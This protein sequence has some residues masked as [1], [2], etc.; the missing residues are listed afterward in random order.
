MQFI[1]ASGHDL[2]RNLVFFADGTWND[3][4]NPSRITNVNLLWKMCRDA[5]VPESAQ[6][7]KYQTGVGTEGGFISRLTGGAFAKGLDDNIIDA[8]I[9][10]ASNYKPSDRIILIGFSRGAY[11]VRSLVGM[12]NSSGFLD[13][14]SDD[15][16]K[17]AKRKLS[18][19]AFSKYRDRG[20]D[21]SELAGAATHE[22]PDI[23]FLGCWDTVG[24]LGI[25]DEVNIIRKWLKPE[26]Y[27]FNNTKLSDNVVMARHAV[28]ID[29]QRRAYAPT[30]WDEAEDENNRDMKQVWFSGV[31]AN[32]GGGYA[33]RDLSDI[34][35]TWMIDEAKSAG[36]LV[37]P[38]YKDSLNPKPMGQLEDSH[39]GFFGKLKSRPRSVP[40][41]HDA[42]EKIAKEA[43]V[44]HQANQGY[45]ATTTLA[46]DESILLE[47]SSKEQW[48]R[49]N[50]YLEGGATYRFTAHGK[51]YDAKV[52]HG[53][54]GT[55]R[56][57]RQ[58]GHKIGDF[59][60]KVERR[61]AGVTAEPSTYSP[62][63]R[64]EY[65]NWFAL[66]G[67]VADGSGV[68]QNTNE[69]NE[70]D[71]FLI[72]DE[73][74]KTVARGGYLYCYANDAWKFYFNNKGSV[75]LKVERTS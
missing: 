64:F 36:L 43:H 49:T 10:L 19:I 17:S 16:S 38:S 20:R 23:H 54:S 32:V 14:S 72:G 5:D 35:L 58:G 4:D 59:W 71:T 22:T 57:K 62:A 31:H 1:L 48:V 66:I 63:R 9:W 8:Y 45:W 65:A 70:H 74:A 7:V 41:F 6:V 33:I 42:G 30:L 46:P 13:L 2:M 28:S 11:T 55:P 51:W 24:A 53:P 69:I 60:A 3:N 18:E 27:R 44:R 67:V 15:L 26:R 68:D 25:P 29:E 73:V 21:Q 52:A 34:T 61:W 50:L 39:T 12:I 47:V 37:H 56:N 40:N 75:T